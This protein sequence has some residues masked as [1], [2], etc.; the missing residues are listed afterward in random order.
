MEEALKGLNPS[1]ATGWDQLPPK[2][3]KLGATE[4]AL[5]LTNLYNICIEQGLWPNEWKKGEWTP[6][7]KK[8]DKLER[9][10][11]RPAT[12]HIAINKIFEK[13]LTKQ[14]TENFDS[15]LSEYLTAYRKRYSCET[16]WAGGRRG[17]VGQTK[18]VG[19][20]SLHSRAIL[21]AYYKNKWDK[22]CPFCGKYAI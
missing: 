1:K 22:F 4:I 12:V 15:R 14:I 17:F 3:L 5:P 18:P 7:H 13:V 2:A 19:Q 11:Y 16:A 9:K 21:A 6:V 10:N 8:D 20:Y